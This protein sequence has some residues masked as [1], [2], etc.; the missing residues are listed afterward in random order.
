MSSE[1]R[2]V[3]A[4]DGPARGEERN[5][6][7][8]STTPSAENQSALADIAVD[9]LSV[10]PASLCPPFRARVAARQ[11]PRHAETLVQPP[12]SIAVYSTRQDRW[13]S[14]GNP[15]AAFYM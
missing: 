14:R 2:T 1:P 8:P 3:Q 10:I 4:F 12:V 7:S 6:T 15:L 5:L 9:P 13:P 11:R